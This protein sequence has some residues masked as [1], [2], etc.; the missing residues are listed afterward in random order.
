MPLGPPGVGKTSLG[1]SIARANRRAFVRSRWRRAARP[2]SRSRADLPRLAAGKIV[3]ICARQVGHPF[4]ARRD[5]PS[6]VRTF[7]AIGLALLEVLDPSRTR[8]SRDHYLEVDFDLSDVM[9]VCT[10]NSLNLRSRCSS[11]ME[12]IR[13]KAIRRREGRDRAAA[14]DR[15]Q[16]EAQFDRANSI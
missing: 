15:Q 3:A 9:F 10:A 7:A 8:S 4:P 5:R 16:I 2:K 11:R 13:L 1:K 12:I 14:P 6:W